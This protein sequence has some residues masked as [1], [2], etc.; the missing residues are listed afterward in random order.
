MTRTLG[1]VV[2]ILGFQLLDFQVLVLN[3]GIRL[4]N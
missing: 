3:I 1:D 2:L 4:E